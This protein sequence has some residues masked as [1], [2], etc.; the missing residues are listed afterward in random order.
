LSQD[1]DVVAHELT[2]GV[3][4]RTS[5]LIYSNESGALNE[6][7]SDIFGAASDTY[8][9]GG[10]VDSL[11]WKVGEDVYTPSTSGD[12]LRYM[13]NPTQDGYSTDY[14]PERLYSGSCTPSSSN[15]QCGVHGNSG[16][17][18]LAFKLLVTGGTHPR[19]KTTASVPGIG[20]SKAEQIF[21]RAQTTYLTSSSNF[22]AARTAT[23]QAAQDLYGSTDKTAVETAW[24]A[25]GVGSC[26]STGGG[27]HSGSPGGATYCSSSCPCDDGFGDCD[28]NAECASGT[29]CVNDVGP[30]YG[31]ASWV[32]VCEGSAPDPNSC[33]GNCGGQAPGGCWC[34]SSCA[35]YGDCCSDKV[36]VCG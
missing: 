12:A 19:G 16:I 9:R 14:Y 27:C 20:M 2:H 4:E 17:A 7:W 36:S 30:N 26:P 35:S 22:S 15:D 13:A 1:A 5:G 31:W 3:T 6:A 23:A 32:D 29:T 33:V 25:V 11:T 28:S 18:N 21:Y 10:T 24:C 34:D 8:R